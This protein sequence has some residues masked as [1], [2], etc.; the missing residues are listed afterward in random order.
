MPK[1]PKSQLQSHNPWWIRPELIKEDSSILELENQKYQ[2]KPEVF[3]LEELYQDSIL[4][5]RGPRQVGKT[6][7]QKLLIKKLLLQKQHPAEGVFYYACDRVENYDQ[8]ADII[9]SYLD[10][11]R[12]RVDVRLFVFLDE[13][14]FVEN[15]QR[16][17]K[18]LADRGKLTNTTL[19]FTG[20]NTLDLKHSSERMP[21]RRGEVRNPD[22]KLLPLDFRQFLRLVDGDL[23]EFATEEL[24]QR[25]LP[26][27]R[28]YFEDYLLTGGFLVNINEYFE[29]EYLSPVRFQVYYN[30]IEGD[31]HKFGKSEQNLLKLSER[32]E[33]HLTSTVSY[34]KLAKES[35]LASYT[36]AKDYIEALEKM[37]VMNGLD[38]YEIAQRKPDYKKNHK[39]YFSDPFIASTLLA[40]AKGFLDDPFRFAKTEQISEEMQ[41]IW[42]ESVVVE[43]FQRHFPQVYY[44]QVGDKEIDIAARKRDRFTFCEVKYQQEVN[45]SDFKWFLDQMEEEEKLIVVTQSS[46]EEYKDITLIPREVFLVR[47]DNFL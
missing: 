43:L 5:V 18:D 41:P 47:Y 8:L 38:Y 31:V 7:Y 26:K 28:K 13:I 30:W 29:K 1:I 24:Y 23:V 9:E 6:T 39:F 19:L 14:S 20:S 17:V 15:W 10:Y 37:F 21:G 16:A 40:K 22:R 36:T 2:Y 45:T 11:A 25:H 42:S 4:T 27:L 12:S 3:S 46:F 32:I 44:G 34:N 33:Q 35:G